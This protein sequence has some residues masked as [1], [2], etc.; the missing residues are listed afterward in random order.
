MSSKSETPQAHAF[1]YLRDRTRRAHLEGDGLKV[2]SLCALALIH[3]QKL[4]SRH[5]LQMSVQ[6]LRWAFIFPHFWLIDEYMLRTIGEGLASFAKQGDP[7]E[8]NYQILRCYHYLVERPL[9]GVPDELKLL[10]GITPRWLSSDCQVEDAVLLSH[11]VELIWYRGSG[12]AVWRSLVGFWASYCPPVLRKRLEDL[13]ARLDLQTKLTSPDARHRPIERAALQDLPP[14][15]PFAKLWGHLLH[16]DGAGLDEAVL[17]MSR[18]TPPES[19][20]ARLLFDFHH[21]NRIFGDFGEPQ[22]IG[23]TRRRLFNQSSPILTFTDARE[24]HLSETIGRLHRLNQVGEANIR[25]HAFRLS[26]LCE[27]AALRL[28]DWAAWRESIQEQAETGFELCKW[29]T[30]MPE[31]PAHSIRLMVQCVGYKRKDKDPLVRNAFDQLEFVPE[32]VL[33]QL[34]ESLLCGYP[35]QM[36]SAYEAL[37]DLGDLIPERLW[38]G[39]ARWSIGYA[40]QVRKGLRFGPLVPLQF[41]EQILPFVS[42]ELE[43]WDLLLPEME[44]LAANPLTWQFDGKRLFRSWLLHAP[45]A[46][47]KAVGE[48]LLATQ[49]DDAHAVDERQYLLLSAEED[50]REFSGSFSRILVNTAQSDLARLPI[51]HFVPDIEAAKIKTTAKP[52]VVQALRAFIARSTPPLAAKQGGLGYGPESLQLDV[53]WNE[54]D[55]PLVT[56]LASAID[57]PQVLAHTL[58][59]LLECLRQLVRM[60]P[61]SFA[62]AIFERY[63]AWL[64]SPPRGRDVRGMRGGPFSMV[65]FSDDSRSE[66][67]RALGWLSLQM[68]QKLGGRADTAIGQWLQR[69]ALNPQSAAIPIMFYLGTQIALRTEGPGQAELLAICENMLLGLWSRRSFDAHAQEYLAQALRFLSQVLGQDASL[70]SAWKPE[71]GQTAVQQL[72]ARLPDLLAYFGRSSHGPV[73]AAVAALL[74]SLKR[75]Q[76]LS[77]PLAQMLTALA[78]DNRA[79]VRFAANE[80][81]NKGS[82]TDSGST[83]S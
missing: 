15:L 60:G 34:V 63:K 28:W 55:L 26:M 61:V 39:V 43:L 24:A 59:G 71:T 13:Q 30:S 33:A 81:A 65:Q 74:T 83:N 49:T 70:H 14:G 17:K 73:R 10:S 6:Q 37:E 42:A 23:L 69:S 19:Y 66:I 8:E 68:S 62:E 11:V 75:W 46:K 18:T 64:A 76:P 79:R 67:Q 3:V 7:K 50:R 29:E 78:Q 52:S 1:S 54:D 36:G 45:L 5:E 38:P 2:N 56:D 4:A 58:P 57:S 35:I 25:I 21:H 40:D 22:V 77:E 9:G 80:G 16:C 20:A 51:A 72:V 12:D 31:V 27:M 47:A 48:A 41:W 32:A 82:P 44:K 53:D